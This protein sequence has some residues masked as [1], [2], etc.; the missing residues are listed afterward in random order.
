MKILNLYAGLG[1]NRKY[2]DGHE[3]VAVE[4][5]DR[6]AKAYQEQYPNDELVVGDAHEFLLNNFDSV[7]FIWSSPPCQSHSKMAKY[8]RNRKPRYVDMKLYEEIMF[9]Q[10]YAKDTYWLVE[11]VVPHYKPFIEPTLKVGRHLIWTNIPELQL[12]EIKQPADFINLQ[13]AEGVRKLKE[14][15]GINYTGNIYYNGNHDPSQVLRNAVHPLIGQQVIKH[16]ETL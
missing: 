7:D 6:I 9:L 4:Y 2:W 16:L 14:W 13:N 12:D 3:V 10:T 8:G 1:G 15:L 5:S 11:N